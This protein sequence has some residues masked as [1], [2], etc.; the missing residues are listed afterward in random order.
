M[1]YTIK[2][3][4]STVDT[5]DSMYNAVQD[6]ADFVQEEANNLTY[7]V[8]NN[9]TGERFT[10]D[11]EV[12]KE[13]AILPNNVPFTSDEEVQAFIQPLLDKKANEDNT[14]DLDAYA[15]GLIHAYKTLKK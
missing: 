9:E 3:N 6:F 11:L 10:V 5:D 12:D 1:S 13:D 7:D 14:I 15:L 4:V 8:T 2:L